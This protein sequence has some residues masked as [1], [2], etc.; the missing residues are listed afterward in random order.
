MRINVHRNPPP[1]QIL[2]Q[3]PR[4]LL[5][6]ALGTRIQQIIRRNRTTRT[7]TRTQQNHV[8][9]RRHIRQR[10]LHKKVR[11]LDVERVCQIEVLLGRLL[12]RVHDG[13]CGVGDQDVDFA[14]GAPGDGLGDE[15]LEVFDG[16]GI[17]L[18]G[19]GLVGADFLDEG[20]GGRG[21]RGVVYDYAGAEGGEEEGG[22][23][24]D[25]F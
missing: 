14:R 22:G 5:H 15:A 21:V 6:R 8:A 7:Q 16:P 10:L 3:H 12:H 23:G 20:I 11:P 2:R 19:D 9:A 13:G 1:P 25:A 4:H 24:T 17:G 18:D